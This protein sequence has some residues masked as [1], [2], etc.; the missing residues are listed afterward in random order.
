[1]KL[2]QRVIEKSRIR[3]VETAEGY[4]RYLMLFIF[5]ALSAILS[6]KFF[7]LENVSNLLKQNAPIGIVTVGELLVI[8]TGGIDLSVGAVASLCG[9]VVATL[10]KEGMAW[11]LACVLV[12]AIGVAAGSINGILVTLAKITP[13]IATLASMTI[14]QGTGLLLSNGRQ[15]F[16]DCPGFLGLGGGSIGFFPTIAVFWVGVA[17]VASFLLN[18]SIAGRFIRGIG[19][20]REAVRLAGVPV[21]A[22]EVLAYSVSGLLAALAGVLMASRLTLGSNIVGEGW[23]LIAIASVMIGGGTFV[24]GIGTVGGTIIGVIVLSLIGNIMNLLGISIYWQ[25][26]VRGLTI[27]AAVMSSRRR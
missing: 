13:F 20:N 12:L 15:V 4:S 24:G 8:L 7:T 27:V 6:P 2:A 5:V 26:I 21:V 23:E 3:L 9:I 16:F 14:Y 18:N 10:L 11:Q 22:Y 1:M 19:G 17:L 25:Q